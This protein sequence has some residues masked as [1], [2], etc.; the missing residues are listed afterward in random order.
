VVGVCL[1]ATE[2]THVPNAHPA[3][4]RQAALDGAHVDALAACLTDLHPRYAR[5]DL[6]TRPWSISCDAMSLTRLLGIVKPIPA[7]APARELRVGGGERWG[8]RSHAR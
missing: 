3:P 1:P 4:L 7:A 8:C 6:T 2:T 5:Y